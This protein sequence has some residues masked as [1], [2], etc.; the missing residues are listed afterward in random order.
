ME[1]QKFKRL[2][3]A[4]RWDFSPLFTLQKDKPSLEKMLVEVEYQVQKMWRFGTYR[5]N[6]QV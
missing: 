1:E 4:A 5:M 2:Q 3:Q 6:L